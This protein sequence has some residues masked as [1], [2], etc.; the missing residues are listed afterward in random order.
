MNP[1]EP[2]AVGPELIKGFA[3]WFGWIALLASLRASAPIRLA[4]FLPPS[5]SWDFIASIALAL[6]AV[7]ALG[8]LAMRRARLWFGSERRL[9]SLTFTTI[10][11]LIA[12]G[13]LMLVST[14][15]SWDVLP[16]LPVHYRTI[17]F[18]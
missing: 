8:A 14:P 17:H 16:P 10:K 13:A 12:I 6:S 2:D 7:E 1:L 9:D 4:P 18:T 15:D 3:S 5:Q 11:F